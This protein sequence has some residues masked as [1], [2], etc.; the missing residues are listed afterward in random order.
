MFKICFF[1]IFPWAG[2][3]SAVSVAAVKRK[4]QTTKRRPEVKRQIQ[5][6]AKRKPI[7]VLVLVVNFLVRAPVLWL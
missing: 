7:L 4:N 5:V 6:G 1:S 2:K 3:D